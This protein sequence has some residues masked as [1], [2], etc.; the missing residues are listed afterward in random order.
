M[1]DGMSDANRPYS[2]DDIA[3]LGVMHMTDCDLQRFVATYKAMESRVRCHCMR[4]AGDDGKITSMCAWHDEAAQRLYGSA[5]SDLASER[6]KTTRLEEALSRMSE[7]IK[8]VID[9]E[10]AKVE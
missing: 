1:S 5:A 7:K 4:A 6:I 10:M 8:G 2:V 3:G 9:S